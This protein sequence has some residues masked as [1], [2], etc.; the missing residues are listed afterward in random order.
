MFQGAYAQYVVTLAAMV[1]LKPPHLSFADAAGIPEVWLTAFQALFLVSKLQKGE[2]I[3]VHA[4]ASGVGIAANQLA[5][6]LGACVP[7]CSL[8]YCTLTH[9]S[10]ADRKHV[11]T[12]AGSA[13]KLDF[14]KEMPYPPTH[15]VDYKTEDFA[16]RV[17]EITNE[18]GVDVI[19]DFIGKVRNTWITRQTS[20]NAHR[21][22]VIRI[23]GRK[24][25]PPS[26]AMGEWSTWP[27]CRET[28]FPRSQSCLFST[29]ASI[30]SVRHSE[31]GRRSTKRS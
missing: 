20:P 12:T 21:P 16:E 26:H 2:S 19:I 1:A 4:G 24:I 11:I 8:L 15:V 5:R 22:D 23:I 9:A 13:E 7:S 17:K 3:L 29:S 25:S 27:R 14:L 28:R 31:Q 18:N 10:F 30:S 6:R